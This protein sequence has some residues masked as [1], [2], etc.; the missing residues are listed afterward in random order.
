MKKLFRR[1]AVAVLCVYLLA[2]SAFAKELVPVGKVVGLELHNDQVVVVG[3]DDKNGGAAK[4]AGLCSGDIIQK[5]NDVKITCTEDVRKALP[6]PLR[7]TESSGE[8]FWRAI[9][10]QI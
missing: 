2:T 7:I 8:G 1:T 5:V 3:F 4:S 9:S 6:A 10:G